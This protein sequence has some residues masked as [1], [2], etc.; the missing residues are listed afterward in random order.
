[1]ALVSISLRHPVNCV[2]VSLCAL[3]AVNSSLAFIQRTIPL[4]DV[5]AAE[6]WIF[7]AK[8]KSIDVAADTMVLNVEKKLKGTAPRKQFAVMLFGDDKLRQKELKSQLLERIESGQELMVFGSQRST[9][10]TLFAYTNGTWFQIVGE[11]RKDESILYNVTHFEP[12][13][14]RTF[15]GTTADLQQVIIDGL[16]G[17]KSPPPPDPKEPPG[18][19]PP[20]KK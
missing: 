6:K 4:A 10:T 8:V 16:T 14:R 20:L 18:L 17:K 15:K 12:Y 7:A 11:P 19:G 1:M 9:K 3:V 2:L 5:I 13:L